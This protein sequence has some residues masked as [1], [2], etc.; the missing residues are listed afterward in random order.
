MIMECVESCLRQ[1]YPRDRYDVVVISDRMEP[2]TNERLSALP[3][4]LEVV[5]FENS[6][7]VKALNLAMSRLSDYDLALI[8]DADNVIAP[9]YLNQINAAPFTENIVGYQTHRMAKIK[10]RA[11]LASMP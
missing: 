11:L 9:D 8:L 10:T 7:K 1:N 5:H 6:T 3:L 2:E 4:I